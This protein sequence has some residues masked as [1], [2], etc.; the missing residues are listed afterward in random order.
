MPSGAAGVTLNWKYA[1]PALFVVPVTTTDL[2]PGFI[3]VS[4]TL[5]PPTGF[6]S[7]SVT[8]TVK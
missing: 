2:P 4:E 7:W 8:V 5:A 3:I 1:W 6:P